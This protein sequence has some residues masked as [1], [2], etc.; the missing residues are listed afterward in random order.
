MVKIAETGRR[1]VARG[2]EIAKDQSYFL[3]MLTQESLGSILFPLGNYTK[4][5]VRAMAEE[6]SLAVAKKPESQEI[7]FIPD[8]RY[9][10]FIER[11][12]GAGR[13]RAISLTRAAR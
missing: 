11:E 6:R 2:A 8:N 1:Y 7:C 9:A 5:Q 3:S 10:E 4:E 12:T 13:D